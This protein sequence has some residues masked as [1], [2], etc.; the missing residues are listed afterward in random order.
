MIPGLGRFRDRG[1]SSASPSA[2]RLAEAHPV[3]IGVDGDAAS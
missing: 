1:A 2:M 3:T